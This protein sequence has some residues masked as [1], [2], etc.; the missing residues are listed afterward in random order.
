MQKEEKFPISP[1]TFI[2]ETKKSLR[3]S[4]HGIE[5]AESFTR[6]HTRTKF[7]IEKTN[8]ADG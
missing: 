3:F 1:F 4:A 6:K 7:N 2:T 8:D 5:V